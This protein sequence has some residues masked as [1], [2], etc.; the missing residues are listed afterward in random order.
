MSEVGDKFL[1]HKANFFMMERLTYIKITK[2]FR[3]KHVSL[4]R[5]LTWCTNDLN[6]FDI[7]FD[8]AHSTLIHSFT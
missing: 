1:K 2:E 5:Y 4:L 8:A 7:F 6:H 3:E